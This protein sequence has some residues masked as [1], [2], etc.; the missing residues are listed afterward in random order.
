MWIGLPSFIG[1]AALGV[2]EIHIVEDI[3]VSGAFDQALSSVT[4]FMHTISKLSNWRPSASQVS[5]PKF[6]F[7]TTSFRDTYLVSGF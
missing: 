6:V 4:Y 7:F 3:T 1:Y 2:L 5:I